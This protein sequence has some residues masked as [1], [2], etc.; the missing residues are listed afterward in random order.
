MS[1]AFY[2]FLMVGIIGG[3]VIEGLAPDPGLPV[4]GMCAACYFGHVVVCVLCYHYRNRSR[5]RS[6]R[7]SRD[8]RHRR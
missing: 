7:H 6:N 1:I 2:M 4:R 8:S 3:T 5:D